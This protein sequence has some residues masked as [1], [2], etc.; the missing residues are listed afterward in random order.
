[1]KQALIRSF[2]SLIAVTF[3]FIGSTLAWILSSNN[4]LINPIQIKFSPNDFEYQFF[5]YQDSLFSGSGSKILHEH[6]CIDNT[7]DFCFIEFDE[8]TPYVYSTSSQ[9]RP[10][11]RF[12]FALK[13]TNI[14]DT[15]RLL[16]VSL[17]KLLS[18]GFD[19]G[20]NKAQRAFQYSTTKVVYWSSNQESVDMKDL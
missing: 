6:L 20:S 17:T 16:L 13:V 7:D 4:S 8:Q 11:N 3:L 5:I 18:T 2:V 9:L 12:S 1:M 10:S 19:L 14:S 15:N